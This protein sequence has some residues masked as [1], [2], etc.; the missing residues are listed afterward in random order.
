MEPDRE[1]AERWLEVYTHLIETTVKT[2]AATRQYLKT[3]PEPARRY[4]ARANVDVMEQE[5]AWFYER[6]SVWAARLSRFTD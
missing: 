2:L 3:L 1:G 4:V 6:R 5:L